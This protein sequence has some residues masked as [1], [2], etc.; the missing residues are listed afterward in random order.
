MP[1]NTIDPPMAAYEVVRS[2]IADLAAQAGFST[3]A[4]R[5]ADPAAIAVSTPHRVAILGLNRIRDAK[6]LR[7]AVDLKG[8]RFL[9]HQQA[10][11]I[12]AV[13]AVRGDDD[14]FRLGQLNEGPFVTGTESAIRRAESLEEVARGQFA[15]VFLLVPAVYVAALWLEDQQG[16][17]DLVLAMPPVP[18]DFTPF[19]P[20][21]AASFLAA[22]KPLAALVPA[23]AEKAKSR[24]GG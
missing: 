10:A 23:E 12:A 17:K 16:D 24:S 20:M 4:L 18:K 5:R 22:L 11:V 1:L 6:D 8:W 2:T 9:V 7:S 13:D 14:Q 3:P 21:P 19:S 15:P